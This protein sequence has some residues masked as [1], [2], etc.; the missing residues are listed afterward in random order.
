MS[1]LAHM[2]LAGAVTSSV[3]RQHMGAWTFKRVWDLVWAT[4]S[5]NLQQALE[6]TVEIYEPEPSRRRVIIHWCVSIVLMI[7]Y[8]LVRYSSYRYHLTLLQQYEGETQGGEQHGIEEMIERKSSMHMDRR[9]GELREPEYGFG[10]S[11]LVTVQLILWLFT[12][13]SFD[14]S[15]DDTV[16]YRHP[17]PSHTRVAIY[18][19]L[20]AGM[21]MTFMAGSYIAPKIARACSRSKYSTETDVYDMQQMGMQQQ[22]QREGMRLGAVQ[23]RVRPHNVSDTRRRIA[24]GQHGGLADVVEGLHS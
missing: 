16:K 17:E 1:H 9:T 24:A 14:K 3:I 23:G 10:S 12:V 6:D 22:Q 2:A 13:L 21:F 19:S 18:W 5:F 20:A 8:L 4:T 7:L 11:L 15:I